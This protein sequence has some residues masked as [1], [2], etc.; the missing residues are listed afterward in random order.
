MPARL[1]RVSSRALGP[2]NTVRVWIYDTVEE[3]RAAAVR[4]SPDE[5]FSEAGGCYQHRDV[6]RIEADGSEKLIESS[7]IVRLWRERLGS[8]V[9]THE[10]NHAAVSIYGRSL[11][12][13]TLASE[14]L[15]GANEELAYLASDLTMHLVDALYANGY[16]DHG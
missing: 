12:D 6:W 11:P 2:R 8:D 16:Y 15:H 4:H 10:M 5:D 7:D 9:T 13:D 14:V 3:L 1:I